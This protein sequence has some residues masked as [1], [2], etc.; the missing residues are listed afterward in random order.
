M[1]AGEVEVCVCV[2]II[3]CCEESAPMEGQ[4]RKSKLVIEVVQS[5]SFCIQS[6]KER[7]RN[8]KLQK[9]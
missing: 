5:K 6:E 4:E 3:D 2:A 9:S 1:L 8:W 7:T